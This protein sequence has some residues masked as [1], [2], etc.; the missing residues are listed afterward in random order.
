MNKLLLV[1]VTA[2]MPVVI[3]A[4]GLLKKRVEKYTS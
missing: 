1:T 2:R 4:L 3:G